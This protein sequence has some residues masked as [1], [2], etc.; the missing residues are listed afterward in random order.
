MKKVVVIGSGAGGATIAKELQG[1]FDVTVLEAGGEFKP[2][3]ANLRTV[4]AL[5]KTQLFFDEREIQLLFPHMRISKTMD[6]MVL[7]RGHGTGGTTTLSAGNAL[8]QDSALKEI[9][10][11]LDEEF[12]EIYNEIPITTDHMNKWSN[13]SLSFMEIAKEMKL[14][15]VPIPKLGNY[16][17]CRKCGQCVLGC[18]HGVKWDSRKFMTDAKNRGASIVLKCSAKAVE[19]EQDTYQAKGVWAKKHGRNVFYPADIIVIAAGGLATPQILEASNISCESKLFVDPVLCVAANVKGVNMR[20]ELSM[21]F[22]VEHGNTIISPYFDFLSFFFNKDWKHPSSDIF[23]LMIKLADS[24]IGSCKEKRLTE[25]D[26]KSLSEAVAICTSMFAEYGVA[27]E[28]VFLGTINAGHPG[29]MFPLTEKEAQSLH[30]DKLPQNVYI[31]DASL[32]PE[33]L[34]NPPILTIIALAKK[35]SKKICEKF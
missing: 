3:S 2:F 28:D 4:E 30:H 23:S 21:P 10:I 32:F 22:V 12:I 5:R 31:A 15:P 35:I 17:Q 27:K 24:N 11:D 13:T 25:N 26:K 1:R 34:G 9:G 7:V 20:N 33:S 18:P 14:D 29:G 16:S 6:K 8:R 19:I